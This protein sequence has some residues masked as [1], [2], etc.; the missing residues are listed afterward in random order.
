VSLAEWAQTDAEW[1][2]E[3]WTVLSAYQ[4]GRQMAQGVETARRDMQC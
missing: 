4:E 2:W 1:F 3:V